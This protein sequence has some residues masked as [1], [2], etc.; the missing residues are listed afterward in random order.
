MELI[1]FYFQSVYEC[2]WH[3]S[4]LASIGKRGENGSAILDCD[5]LGRE[6]WNRRDNLRS[7]VVN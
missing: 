3:G 2:L 7:E 5:R 1:G 6:F 4:P